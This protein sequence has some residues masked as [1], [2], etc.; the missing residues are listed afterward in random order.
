M[1][2]RR[3]ERCAFGAAAILVGLSLLTCSGGQATTIS[4]SYSF[5]A[6][7]P[8]ESSNSPPGSPPIAEISGSFGFTYSYAPDSPPIAG[9][10]PLILPTF[11]NLSFDVTTFTVADTRIVLEF[12]DFSSIGDAY[13]HLGVRLE[14]RDQMH[15]RDGDYFILTFEVNPDGT[16]VVDLPPLRSTFGYSIDNQLPGGNNFFLDRAP[17]TVSVSCDPG[18]CAVNDPPL[19]IPAPVPGPI[20]GAG[21]PGLILASGGLLGWW[22]RRQKT[23]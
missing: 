9:Q 17:N 8:W 21:L 20:A 10:T 5:T 18:Y 3:K 1:R 13:T 4:G 15:Q 7:G 19:A 11:L 2:F 22:R 23:A 14:A 16:Q 12:G 6:S